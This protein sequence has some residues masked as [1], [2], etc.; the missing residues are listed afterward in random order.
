VAPV[1]SGAGYFVF[2]AASAD[3]V[4]SILAQ[5]VRPCLIICDLCMPGLPVSELLNRIAGDERSRSVPV[6]LMTGADNVA[7]PP[8]AFTLLKPFS[9]DELLRVAAAASELF[10]SA[11]SA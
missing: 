6:V 5:G 1:S 8:T 3:E 11:A 2:L 9:G 10:H 4:E 7:R